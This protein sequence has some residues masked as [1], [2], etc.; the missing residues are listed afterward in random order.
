M[1]VR[2]N[3]D[4]VAPSDSMLCPAR[5]GGR[6]HLVSDAKVMAEK[7]SEDIRSVAM[8]RRVF[9]GMIGVVAVIL[10][11]CGQTAVEEI[12]TAPS[13]SDLQTL[14]LHFTTFSKSKS[15]AT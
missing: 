5:L 9:G 8:N 13:V 11:G 6:F 7:G 10:A 4:A 3:E 1:R 14:R 2:C 15:G 12:E